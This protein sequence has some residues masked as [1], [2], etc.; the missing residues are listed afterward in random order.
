[1]L[2]AGWPGSS[3]ISLAEANVRQR[4]AA[5]SVKT[6]HLLILWSLAAIDM[7][8]FFLHTILYLF[9]HA[10]IPLLF[11]LDRGGNLP[12]WHA[13]NQLLIAGL[14]IGVFVIRNVYKWHVDSRC[15][16]RR[17]YRY[18]EWTKR[19]AFMSGSADGAKH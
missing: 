8:F 14:L 4:L 18:V 12:T 2:I 10:G 7:L 3:A 6:N 13:S 15:Y 1:V 11:D 9:S 5:M 16:G 17:M 19:P